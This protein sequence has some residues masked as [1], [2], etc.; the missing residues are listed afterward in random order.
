MQ[1]KIGWAFGFPCLAIGGS[2]MS[3]P[4]MEG[5]WNVL[6]DFVYF[7]RDHVKNETLAFN[8]NICGDSCKKGVTLETSNLTKGFGGEPGIH[9]ALDYQQEWNSLYEAGFLYVWDWNTTKTAKSKSSSLIYPF[10]DPSLAS[11][12]YLASEIAA[13]Y[14]SQFYTLE[15]NYWRAFNLSKDSLLG[16]SGVGGIRYAHLNELFELTSYKGTEFGNY[17]ITTENDLIGIQIGFLFSINAVKHV[18]CDLEGKVGVGLNRMSADSSLSVE[19][20]TVNIRK[21]KQQEFQSNIFAEALAGI[22]YNPLPYLDV[23]FGYQMLYFCGLALAPDQLSTGSSITSFKMY[24]N[25]YVI[26]HGMYAGLL[27][28]F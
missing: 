1:R 19:S 27:F 16:F 22:G 10:K 13:Y 21:M 2:L 23:H 17:D 6:T 12:F 24:R 18:H 5:K 7:V 15:L 26:L 3:Q 8:P 25:G 4:P 28:S 11:D 20:K 9:V 14:Q